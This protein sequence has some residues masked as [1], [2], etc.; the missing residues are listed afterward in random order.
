VT[1]LAWS[2][3]DRYLASVGL[4][5][6]VMIWDGFTLGKFPLFKIKQL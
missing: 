5:S 6:V 4:D 1:G 2:T 3:A